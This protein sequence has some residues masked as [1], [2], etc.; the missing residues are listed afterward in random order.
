MIQPGMDSQ[1][2]QNKM[3]G[4]APATPAAMG[5]D[6]GSPTPASPQDSSFK[7]KLQS[8]AQKLLGFSG[9]TGSTPMNPAEKAAN[10]ISQGF[11][12]LVGPQPQQPAP[13]PNFGPSPQ[14]MQNFSNFMNAFKAGR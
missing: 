10:K 12:A 1:E 9:G 14:V 11:G 4:D 13:M 5:G 8:V 7:D 2:D 6:E 3:P